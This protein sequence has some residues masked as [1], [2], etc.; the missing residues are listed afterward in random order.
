LGQFRNRVLDLQKC[1]IL[2]SK[3]ISNII[4]IV[5]GLVCPPV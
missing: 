4:D 2:N 3:E 5:G 1:A